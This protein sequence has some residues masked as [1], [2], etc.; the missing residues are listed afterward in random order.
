MKDKEGTGW[1][2]PV[3]VLLLLGYPVSPLVHPSG[4][5]S[6]SAVGKSPAQDKPVPVAHLSPE[7]LGQL[8]DEFLGID[9]NR[10]C[11]SWPEGDPR[12]DLKIQRNSSSS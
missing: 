4:P 8:L 5:A 6:S 10:K 2:I 3:I 12:R 7:S 1:F 9:S 11:T